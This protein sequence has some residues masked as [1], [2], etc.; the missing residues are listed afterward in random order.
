MSKMDRIFAKP[1]E[2][3]RPPAKKLAWVEM[4]LNATQT[5]SAGIEESL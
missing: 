1:A 5:P 2:Q 4:P 3:T